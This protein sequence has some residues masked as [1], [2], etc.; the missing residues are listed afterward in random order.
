MLEAEDNSL[1]PSPSTKFWPRGQPVPENLTSLIGY[2]RY[3]QYKLT[4]KIDCT[5][6]RMSDPSIAVTKFRLHITR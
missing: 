5:C 6:M 1:R 3:N 2:T 4:P